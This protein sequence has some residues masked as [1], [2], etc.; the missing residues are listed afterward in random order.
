M[1]VAGLRGLAAA[2]P[3]DVLVARRHAISLTACMF[4]CKYAYLRV[5]EQYDV[6]VGWLLPC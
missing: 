3:R 6:H 4:A 1:A 2:Q 5:G